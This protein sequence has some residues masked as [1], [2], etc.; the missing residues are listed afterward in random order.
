MPGPSGHSETQCPNGMGRRAP[1]SRNTPEQKLRGHWC[2]RSLGFREATSPGSRRDRLAPLLP[3]GAAGQPRAMWLPPPGGEPKLKTQQQ[4]QQQPQWQQQTWRPGASWPLSTSGEGQS[5]AM[6][7][8]QQAAG[9]LGPESSSP[10]EA[11]AGPQS[12]ESDDRKEAGQPSTQPSAP[13]GSSCGGSS[14]PPPPLLSEMAS[15]Q[16]PSSRSAMAVAPS[17]GFHRSSWRSS[18]LSPEAQELDV[19]VLCTGRLGCCDFGTQPEQEPRGL[20]SPVSPHHCLSAS[21]CS[22]D[23][24]GRVV[25]EK[26][27]CHSPPWEE[28]V[29]SKIRTMTVSERCRMLQSILCCLQQDGQLVQKVKV[30]D[31]SIQ[32]V[33]EP[34][35]LDFSSPLEKAWAVSLGGVGGLQGTAL[36]DGLVKGSTGPQ[37]ISL[38]MGITSTSHLEQVWGRLEHLGRTRF[39]RSAPLSTDSQL[40]SDL[41]W[42]WVSSTALLC[43]GQMAVHAG[44]QVLPWVDNITSRMV[45]YFSCSSLVSP[46]G[47][48]AAGWG[49]VRDS[50]LK[51]SFLSASIMLVKALSQESS[52]RSYKFTQTL[53]LI[54]CLLC[55]LEKEPNFLANLFRQKIILVIME[56]SWADQLPSGH[57]GLYQKSTQVLDLLLQAFVSENESMDEICFLLQHA[58]PWLK[59]SKSYKRKR[60]VQSVFLLLKYVADYGKLTEEAMPLGL[61]RQVG[62]LLLLWQDRDQLTQ[63]HSHQCVYLFLQLLI[64]QKGS[65]SLEFMHLNK[66]KN[67]EAKA[68]KDSEL[69]FYSLVKTLDEH[70]TVAQHTQFVL[71]PLQGLC[72]HDGLSCHLAPE[73]LLTIMEDRSIKP[74]QVAEILQEL[75]QELPCIIFTSILQT[76][77]KA[78][79]VLGMQHTQQTVKVIRSLCPPS[80][81]QVTP[82]WKALATNSRLAR[83]VI[84]KMKLW[85]PREVIKAPV[86]AEL[87]SLLALG[88]LYK[89]LTIHEYKATVRWAFAGILLGLLTQLHYLLELDMVEGMSDYQEEALEAKALSPCRTCLEVLKG[90]FWTTNYW[91]VFAHLKVLRG[92]ELFEHLETY[93]EGVTLLA[94]NVIY[95]GGKKFQQAL[96]SRAFQALV[97]LL[98]HLAHSCPEVV[99]GALP[100][101]A[102]HRCGEAL[103]DTATPDVPVRMSGRP[104]R[105]Q[106]RQ[107]TRPSPGVEE[108][109]VEV[110]VDRLGGWCTYMDS[111]NRH[112][113]LT[114]MKFIGGILQVYFTDLCFY[115]KKGDVKTLKKSAPRL[116]DPWVS[117]ADFETLRQDPGSVSRKFYKH[118]SEDI[119][120]LSQERVRAE[121]NWRTAS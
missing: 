86:Q 88:T 62:L 48:R 117:A 18:C 51:A 61:G 56:L 68:H 5:P 21:P 44:K 20:G 120:E 41:H 66:M 63:S 112:L 4:Q 60:V 113:K 50:T 76:I 73:L 100:A 81:R 107:W 72:S 58:E 121:L 90:L 57:Q 43:Y 26:P 119:A 87:V 9:P 75:F 12:Q 28:A 71:T 36:G 103:G 59:S 108:M 94:R 114:A 74:E 89:R 92:W 22:A 29:V 19:G 83:K 42:R 45:Y 118:F 25:A 46:T 55:I 97:P 84:M 109:C 23:L 32:E 16:D 35:N 69:K 54:Q 6:T 79:M 104:C 14:G 15:P 11:A 96:E 34:L 33:L 37:G 101:A 80:E 8:P 115:L 2:P 67:F 10:A 102:P 64:Q 105:S 93:T 17:D 91:E 85:L 49:A 70:L 24:S 99:T 110:D 53:E 38:A 7:H 106:H 82:L 31:A 98:F 47:P 52:A 111:P 77:M 39:L 78:V 95:S 30:S 27:L 65:M 1:S 13:V 40:E 116:E 3:P